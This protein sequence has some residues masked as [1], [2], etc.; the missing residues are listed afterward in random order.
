MQALSSNKAFVDAIKEAMA[1]N[2]NQFEP[3]DKEPQYS[4]ILSTVQRKNAFL[5]KIGADTQ[6]GGDE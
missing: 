2:K 1:D 6:P 5:K 3:K 4:Y